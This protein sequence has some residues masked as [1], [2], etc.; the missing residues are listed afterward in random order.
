MYFSGLWMSLHLVNPKE[1]RLM[2]LLL[3]RSNLLLFQ[4]LLDPIYS[5]KISPLSLDILISPSSPPFIL[6]LLFHKRKKHEY[7]SHLGNLLLHHSNPT[8]IAPQLHQSSDQNWL[9]NYI[10]SP[11]Y[12]F[13]PFLGLVH[14]QDDHHLSCSL[15]TWQER[16]IVI[17]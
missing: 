14:P 10:T 8:P 15:W 2:P 3:E 16:S 17:F 12:P 7:W 1:L 6:A 9:P 11:I 13:Q 5:F 4:I